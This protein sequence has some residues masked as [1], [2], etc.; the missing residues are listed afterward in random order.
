M[1]YAVIELSGSQFLVSEGD[2]LKVNRL[3]EEEGKKLSLTPLLVSLE[4]EVGVGTPLVEGAE[5]QL[6][7]LEHKK[8]KK[9]EVRRFKSKSRYR[10]KKGHRQPVS[11]L[12]VIKISREKGPGSF[13]QRLGDLGLSTRTRNALEKA[14]IKDVA[15]LRRMS[16]EDLL[17]IKGIGEK[18]AEEIQKAVTR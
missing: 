14:G 5:V 18:A 1:N 11:I 16:R 17:E 13:P 10:R 12:E 4:G 9:I 15:E 6:S 3:A 8:D 7:I 2:K